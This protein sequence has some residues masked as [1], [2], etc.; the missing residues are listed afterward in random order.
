[1]SLHNFCREQNV[2]KRFWSSKI[3]KFYSLMEEL[4]QTLNGIPKNIPHPD[5]VWELLVATLEKDLEIIPYFYEKLQNLSSKE[6][7]FISLSKKY[8]SDKLEKLSNDGLNFDEKLNLSKQF[9]FIFQFLDFEI[10]EKLIKIITT[11][12]NN[13]ITAIQNLPNQIISLLDFI[14]YSN[15]SPQILQKIFE[16]FHQI[17]T[18]PSIVIMSCFISDIFSVIPTAYDEIPTLIEELCKNGEK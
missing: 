7:S 15:L 17:K 4:F 16:N 12:A 2:T 13:E 18:I 10:Q 11:L 9:I 3:T 1:M 14:D 5:K 8:L 6:S